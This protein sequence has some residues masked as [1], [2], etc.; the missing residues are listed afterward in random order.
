MGFLAFGELAFLWDG[1]ESRKLEFEGPV[2][3]VYGGG[4]S[5]NVIVRGCFRDQ[6]NGEE[7]EVKNEKIG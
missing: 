3:G 5:G 1:G 4:E 7:E 6:V 2:Y